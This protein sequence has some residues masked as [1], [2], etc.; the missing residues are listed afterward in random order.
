MVAG[1]KYHGT[2]GQPRP[3]YVCEMDNLPGTPYTMACAISAAQPPDAVSRQR[4]TVKDLAKYV[5]L[6]FFFFFPSWP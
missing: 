4:N 6:F 1:C 3:L 2:I 5:P